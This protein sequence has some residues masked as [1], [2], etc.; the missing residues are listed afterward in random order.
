MQV[1]DCGMVRV[2]VLDDEV[3]WGWGM[4]QRQLRRSLSVGEPLGPHS[5]RGWPDSRLSLV[6]QLA[7]FL[8]QD[9]LG[10]GGVKLLPAA[11]IVVHPV[12]EIGLPRGIY[13]THINYAT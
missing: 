2:G 5:G 7:T 8:P 6:A 13:R 9:L 10:L 4:V 12:L 11:S 3:G 1:V